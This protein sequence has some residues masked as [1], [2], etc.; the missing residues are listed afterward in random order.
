L[1]YIHPKDRTLEHSATSGAGPYTLSGAVDLSFK[2]FS[3][4]MSVGDTTIG[5][6]V[7]PGVAFWSGVL[8][9]SAANQ[10]TA[11]GTAF[12][13]NGTF[14]AGTK[15]IF[16][17]GPAS[18]TPLRDS[19]NAF[20][21]LQVFNNTTEAT[22]A[23]TTAAML[24]AGGLEIAKKLFVGGAVTFASTLNVGGVAQQY[25]IKNQ[26][27]SPYVTTWANDLNTTAGI[28]SNSTGAQDNGGVL[29][30]GGRTGNAFDYYGFGTIKGAKQT[31][32]AD[33]NYGGYLALY[34]STAAGGQGE[35]LRGD[36]AQNTV[37][38]NSLIYGG[39]TLTGAVTGTG[40]MVLS[41]APIITSLTLGGGVTGLGNLVLNGGS[42]SGGGAF[43]QF[44]KAGTNTWAIG[45]RTSVIGGTDSG[46]NNLSIYNN[47]IGEA[48]VISSSDSSIWVRS[49]TS[50][51]ATSNGALHVDGGVGIGLGLVIGGTAYV[52][53]AL[54]VVGGA[55]FQGAIGS[56]QSATFGNGSVDAYVGANGAVQSG[57]RV[58]VNG[59]W[60][61]FYGNEQGLTGAG[62][63]TKMILY[64]SSSQFRLYST[65]AGTMTTD[66]AGNI[67]ISSDATLKNI[68]GDFTRGLAAVRA[69]SPKLYSWNEESGNETD[70][71]YAGFIAQD[72]LV[73]IPEAIG[74][75]PS[76]K[77]T[78]QDRPLIAALVNAVK[79]MA[80][81]ID[82][83]KLRQAA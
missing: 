75:M 20:D 9:Y 50:S 61:G 4:S 12:D 14:G 3:A 47:S 77:L 52:G 56:I 16:M 70:G 83:L 62:S 74:R 2:A 63:T 6:I 26:F 39:V 10:V 34:S 8:T 48:L 31:A 45:D 25:N 43:L 80:N 76:G 22:G 19:N 18:R 11:T 58:L 65:G 54:T 79:E 7:E 17:G 73:H 13:S 23:G 64:S 29:L 41:A 69:I 42:G 30:F 21:G 51:S 40:K 71:I 59:T 60:V 24:I 36:A 38:K 15:E 72:I 35:F 78:L 28:F 1:A 46:L 67:V 33:N 27:A 32:A 49:S 57:F 68:K 82:D 37:I 55:T 53:G 5:T 66:G 44:L 81:E